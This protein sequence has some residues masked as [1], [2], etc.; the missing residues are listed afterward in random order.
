MSLKTKEFL[1]GLASH[2]FTP[3]THTWLSPTSAHLTQQFDLRDGTTET[4]PDC[5]PGTRAKDTEMNNVRLHGL[6]CSRRG[7]SPYRRRW[8]ESPQSQGRP[9]EV[10]GSAHHLLTSQWAPDSRE[11]RGSEREH[12]LG[13]AAPSAEA[14]PG[15]TLCPVSE[16]K[17][18]PKTGEVKGEEQ[19][20]KGCEPRTAAVSPGL[21][22]NLRSCS[23]GL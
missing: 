3:V 20:G 4:E 21:L 5:A 14:G 8:Q 22:G 12:D 1:P 2:K 15:R 23:P 19:P 18:S 11:N 10:D 13:S 6:S 9:Q 7:R 17:A 16:P